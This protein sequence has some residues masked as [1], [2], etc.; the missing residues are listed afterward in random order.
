MGKKLELN[1]KDLQI[2]VYDLSGGIVSAIVQLG[3]NVSDI[4]VNASE[5][6]SED[7]YNMMV[8]NFSISNIP[9]MTNVK[10]FTGD[11]V[12]VLS[13]SCTV[14]IYMVETTTD[15][16]YLV[17]DVITST[18]TTDDG[19]LAQR[20]YASKGLDTMLFAL[21]KSCIVINNTVMSQA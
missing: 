6:N 8:V 14:S 1:I 21:L 13:G 3:Y 20:S 9:I 16:V 11:V 12:N 4:T 19:A 7:D 10:L 17:E 2:P 15:H 18:I 5:A